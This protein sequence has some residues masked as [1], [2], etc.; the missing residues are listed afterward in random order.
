MHGALLVGLGG[1]LVTV[2]VELVANGVTGGAGTVLRL[3]LAEKLGQ[4]RDKGG[5]AEGRYG[6]PGADRDVGVLGDL[7]VGLLGGL[8]G[9]S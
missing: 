8:V 2:L 3:W 6:L 5:F 1:S 7:L 4:L 9:S